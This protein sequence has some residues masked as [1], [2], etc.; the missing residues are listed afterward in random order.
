MMRPW[1]QIDH[2]AGMRLQVSNIDTLPWLDK[3]AAART[4][5]SATRRIAAYAYWT[6]TLVDVRS[7]DALDVRDKICATYGFIQRAM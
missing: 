1:I 3:I 5:D 7:S 6:Y 4:S 2:T